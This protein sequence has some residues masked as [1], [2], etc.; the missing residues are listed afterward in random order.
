[1]SRDA[2]KT[3]TRLTGSE[4]FVEISPELAGGW[5]IVHGG[6]LTTVRSARPT[7]EARAMVF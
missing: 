4:I 1:L 2:G 7:I 6:W 3:R 5:G